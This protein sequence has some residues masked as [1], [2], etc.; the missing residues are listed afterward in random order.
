MAPYAQHWLSL[1]RKRQHASSATAPQLHGRGTASVGQAGRAMAGTWQGHI[2]PPGDHS[3]CSLTIQ[4]SQPR[5]QQTSPTAAGDWGLSELTEQARQQ[6]GQ[7]AHCRPAD[8]AQP[9]RQCVG[10]HAAATMSGSTARTSRWQQT[11]SGAALLQDDSAGCMPSQ[12]LSSCKGAVG[13]HRKRPAASDWEPGTL[14]RLQ[15]LRAAAWSAQAGL[16]AAAPSKQELHSP[17][18]ARAR[19]QVCRSCLWIQQHTCLSSLHHL[20]TVTLH[21]TLF[22]EAGHFHQRV[23]ARLLVALPLVLADCCEE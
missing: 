7:Q 2:F 22:E 16:A 9:A 20:Q 3:P 8:A 15:S 5:L 17:A 13:Q 14:H 23:Q 21:I 6:Q 18:T 1:T 11:C 4:R 12:V 19:P 10:S